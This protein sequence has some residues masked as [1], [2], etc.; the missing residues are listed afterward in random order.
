M[1]L[2]YF[3]IFSDNYGQGKHHEETYMPERG[4]VKSA[5]PQ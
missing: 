2:E 1:Y 5:N 4:R 3:E